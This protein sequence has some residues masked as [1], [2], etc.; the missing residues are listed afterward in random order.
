MGRR[1]LAVPTPRR[2]TEVVPRRRTRVVPWRMTEVDGRRVTKVNPRRVTEVL[3]RRVTGVT[4]PA[5]SRAL[6]SP[7]CSIYRDSIPH[8]G[9]HLGGAFASDRCTIRPPRAR[10][11]TAP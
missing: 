6:S 1:P 5:T 7:P 9:T 8:D 2:R 3:P 11:A 4:L 10:G